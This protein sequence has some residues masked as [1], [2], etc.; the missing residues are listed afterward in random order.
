MIGFNLSGAPILFRYSWCLISFRIACLFNFF[1]V[2]LLFKIINPTL[3]LNLLKIG[4][5][6]RTKEFLL[7]EQEWKKLVGER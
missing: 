4:M 5:V 7:H 2:Q 6:N 1:K 3:P